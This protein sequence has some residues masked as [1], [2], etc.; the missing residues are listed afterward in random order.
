MNENQ[1]PV[2]NW[3]H[4]AL[5]ALPIE[6]QMTEPNERE[7][8]K[9]VRIFWFRSARSTES[10]KEQ[11]STKKNYKFRYEVFMSP[12]G[13]RLHTHTYTPSQYIQHRNVLCAQ[14]S[15]CIIPTE[16]KSTPKFVECER[17]G[18]REIYI[19]VHKI[20]NE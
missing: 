13:F 20:G 6:P 1:C 11:P 7:R 9:K 3:N 5:K 14:C 18:A 4:R 12:I 19:R 8:E 2:S 16:E 17:T 10:K 15:H